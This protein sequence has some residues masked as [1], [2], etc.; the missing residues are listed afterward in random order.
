[1]SPGRLFLATLGACAGLYAIRFCQRHDIAYQGLTIQV[2]DQSAESPPRVAAAQITPSFPEPI[3]D[4]Y[5]GAVIRAADQCYVTQSIMHDMD[6]YVSLADSEESG[7]QEHHEEMEEAGRPQRT[8]TETDEETQGGRTVLIVEDNIQLLGALRATLERAGYSVL[9]SRDGGEGAQIF[10][11][12]HQ[13][14]DAV[15]MDWKM[16]GLDGDR[17]VGTMLSIDSNAR[18]IFYTAYEIPGDVRRE[19]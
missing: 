4:K 2:D 14:I 16:L 18:T 19:L 12:E 1:M 3:P 15:I 11:A 8:Q 17:W 9:E 6:I 13:A 10:R 5:R 7:A